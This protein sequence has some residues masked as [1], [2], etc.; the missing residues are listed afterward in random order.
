MDASDCPQIIEYATQS[1]GFTPYSVAFVPVSAKFV[2]VG[3]F[4]RGS[5]ALQGQ[6]YGVSLALKI[7]CSAR[8]NADRIENC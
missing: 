3:M 1:V 5:G 8:I 7:R 4:A 6:L 2:S